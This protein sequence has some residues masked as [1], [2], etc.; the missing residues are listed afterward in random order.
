MVLELALESWVQ[1]IVVLQR[2]TVFLMGHSLDVMLDETSFKDE[3]T[4]QVC[5]TFE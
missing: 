2:L 5:E 4:I 1:T 3:N